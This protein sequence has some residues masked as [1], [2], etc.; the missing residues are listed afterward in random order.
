MCGGF[1]GK[2]LSPITTL[3]GGG[4]QQEVQQPK[5][6]QNPTVLDNG[7]AALDAQQQEKK[8]KA[9][10]A[11]FNSNILAGNTTSGST[12]TKTLLGE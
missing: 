2:L 8:K 10:N 1:V 5:T 4:R 11:G 6:I 7:E 3:F 12:S 9:Q